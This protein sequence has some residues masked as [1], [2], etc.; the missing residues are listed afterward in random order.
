VK[1]KRRAFSIHLQS[2]R[3]TRKCK[4]VYRSICQ[5]GATIDRFYA[6]KVLL[7]DIGGRMPR[8]VAHE[9]HKIV[10]LRK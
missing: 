3:L 1:Y 2:N 7:T 8:K 9:G 5:N 10:P 4:T 6:D